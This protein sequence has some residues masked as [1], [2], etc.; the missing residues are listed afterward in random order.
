[1]GSNAEGETIESRVEKGRTAMLGKLQADV[2]TIL[3]WTQGSVEYLISSLVQHGLEEASVRALLQPTTAPAPPAPPA[4]VTNGGKRKSPSP[5][6]V[7]LAKRPVSTATGAAPGDKQKRKKKKA[8][9]NEAPLFDQDD[10]STPLREEGVGTASDGLTGLE[11]DYDEF[12]D[13]D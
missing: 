4:A 5:Q 12:S 1:M 11:H 9:V 3:T 8:S 6:P 10:D 2:P 7:A 13:S